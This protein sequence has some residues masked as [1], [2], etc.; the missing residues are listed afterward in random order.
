MKKRFG[1]LLFVIGGLGGYLY[2]SFESRYLIPYIDR[3]EAI[4]GGLEIAQIHCSETRYTHPV[5]CLH[6]TLETIDETKDGWWMTF[7]SRDGHRRD[8][9]WI[10]RRNE[11]DSTGSEN[12]DGVATDGVTENSPPQARTKLQL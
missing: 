2:G 12:L 6:L 3:D 7:V 5:D 8:S 1:C 10:G 4:K 11:Y 9:M